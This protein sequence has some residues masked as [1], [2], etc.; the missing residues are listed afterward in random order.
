MSNKVYRC[1]DHD[2]HCPVGGGSVVVA[3]TA[4]KARELLDAELVKRGLKP[5]K[6]HKYHLVRIDISIPSAHVISDGDY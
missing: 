6:K 3:P 4:M 2:V 5:Y 1:K